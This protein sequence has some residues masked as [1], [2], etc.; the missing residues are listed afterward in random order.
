MRFELFDSQSLPGTSCSAAED[1]LRDKISE[2]H[3]QLSFLRLDVFNIS[4]ACSLS[5][6]S[7]AYFRLKPTKSDRAVGSFA[8]FS[9]A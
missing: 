7:L 3:K 6:N 9:T 4:R 2:G 5:G 8:Q 1:R